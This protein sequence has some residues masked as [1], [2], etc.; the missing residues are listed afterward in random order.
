VVN[1][2]NFK[3][4]SYKVFGKKRTTQ[5]SLS[6]KQN[7]TPKAF[8]QIDKTRNETWDK[9]DIWWKVNELHESMRTKQKL[10]NQKMQGPT[11]MSGYILILFNE[12][13]M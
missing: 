2:E 13:N 6:Q 11:Y 4:S 10:W 9:S 12:I 3:H 5:F 8:L 1:K 7:Y